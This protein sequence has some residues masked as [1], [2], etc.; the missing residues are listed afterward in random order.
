MWNNYKIVNI[1]KKKKINNISEP[2]QGVNQ[3]IFQRKLL[4]DIIFLY[5]FLYKYFNNI[6]DNTF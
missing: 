6:H 2:S 1:K 5:A 3:S 4:N